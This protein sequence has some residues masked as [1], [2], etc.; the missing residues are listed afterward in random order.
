MKQ[1]RT[2]LSA[3]LMPD[4]SIQLE[5][6]LPPDNGFKHSSPVM[7]DEIFAHFT[8]EQDDWLFFLGFCS[9]NIPLSPSL[10]FW[11]TFSILFI[12]K[13]KLTPDLEEL[14]ARVVIPFAEEE[15]E[16]LLKSAPLM[17]GGE[18]LTR[19]TLAIL[20]KGLHDT[21][22]R[23]I[24]ANMGS[25]ADF[26]RKYSPDVHLVGRIYFHLVENKDHEFPFAFL[27]TYSTRLNEA[28]GSRHLPLKYAL[29]EYKSDNEKLLRLLVTV[30][31]AARKSELVANMRDNGELFSPLAWSSREAYVFLQEIPIYEE[32]GILCR[33]PNWWKKKTAAVTLQ[34]SIGEKPP[35][36][37]GMNAL[38][39]F[40]PRLMIGDTEIS[41]EEAR[42]LL[43]ESEGLAFLKNKWVA[44]DPEKLRQTLEAFEKASELHSGEGITLLDALRLSA[45]SRNL[46]GDV[47]ADIADVSH[48]EWLRTVFGQLQRPEAMARVKTSR[49]FTARLRH[50][51]QDG[52]NWLSS[53]HRM[54]LGACL[55][56]DMGLG[57]TVQILAFL[58]VLKTEA[59][60][61]RKT[62]ASLLVIPASLLANWSAEI[63]KFA[64][65]LLFFVAHP[66]YHR[67]TKVPVLPKEKIDGLDLVITT[68]AL[69]QRYE[70]LHDY[71]WNHVILDEAQA[72]KNPATRQAKAVKSLASANR[73]I[74]TGTPVENRL[75]DLWSLFDFINPGLLGTAKE[76]GEFTKRLADRPDGYAGLRRV[77]SPFILRRLKTDTS[78]IS[79]LPDK[80]ELKTWA[81]MSK[82]QTVLYGEVVAT[83][84]EALEHTEGIQRKGLILSAIM[85]FKQLC[86][87]PSQYLGLDSFKEQESG[88]FQRLREICETI[89]EKR[90]RVL[91]FT[92]FK[93]MTGPLSRFLATI[94]NRE[95]LVLHGSVPVGK[96]KELVEKFQGL[97]YVPF[98]VLSL[99]AGGVG[100][101]LTAASHVIHFDRWWNPAVENQATDRAFR[102][103]QKKN[104]MVHKFLTQGTIEEKIDRMLVEKAK[105]SDEVLAASGERWLTEMSNED[106][107]E[108]FTLNI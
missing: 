101:N 74:M 66:D 19:E 45:N 6:T 20:W 87:H 73:I 107:L 58:D 26:L 14:R 85:K 40:S 72:I 21:F 63:E 95:G 99:K 34:V 4:C 5:W 8:Q 28:G 46:Q 44:V 23:K 55:A 91:I 27:A 80:V 93:E 70:W 54:R 62:A 10:T 76:F 17:R 12:R 81:G 89:H 57:K 32:A 11:R 75:A 15:R 49:A 88:K 71:T 48:G 33:I 53:L 94:F 102:I 90:E 2:E 13:L 103:G 16:R 106:L 86:N 82:K 7:Q 22:C 29:E 31:E 83:I 65:K 50:Y 77:V 3:I 98:F 51:Q 84:R 1:H 24:D 25:V 96:R 56:D 59:G 97:D 68:Y 61:T 41:E 108:L 60:K 43:R 78:I 64:P 47:V 42:Q 39:D 105:L 79:D 36:M 104:V 9:E 100:L 67:P 69:V 37:V 92:Q 35:S 18:Y 38:L 52:L 30:D